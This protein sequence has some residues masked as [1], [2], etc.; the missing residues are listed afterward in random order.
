MFRKLQGR[1]FKYTIAAVF[2]NYIP[3]QPAV[4][5]KLSG[6]ASK[7]FMIIT[8]ISVN[9]FYEIKFHKISSRGWVQKS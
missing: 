7:I 3:V 9:Y 5:Q 8:E 6:N 4:Y 2:V 1:P